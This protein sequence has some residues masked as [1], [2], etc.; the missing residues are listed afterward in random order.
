MR[1]ITKITI[2]GIRLGVIALVVYWIMMFV[3]THLPNVPDAA[4]KVDDKVMHFSAF[5]GLALIL[6]YVSEHA[7]RWKRF[8][9]IAIVALLYAGV[10]EFTQG[11]V[12][13]REPDWLD[14]L[15]DASG[16][17]TAIAFYILAQVIFGRL[18]AAR[19][20]SNAA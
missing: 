17:G 20:T 2:L 18:I 1:P 3:G 11:F 13:Q 14:F 16:I 6:C 9:R 10:D 7:P 15:A 5:F 19:A 12:P 4:P 8:G